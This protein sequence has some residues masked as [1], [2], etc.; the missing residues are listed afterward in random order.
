[1]SVRT[2]VQVFHRSGVI[3]FAKLSQLPVMQGAANDVQ[4]HGDEYP[5]LRDY[6]PVQQVVQPCGDGKIQERQK[7]QQVARIKKVRLHDQYQSEWQ[8]KHDK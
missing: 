3:T 7:H 5:G 4:G 2:L 8:N 1:L 6:T